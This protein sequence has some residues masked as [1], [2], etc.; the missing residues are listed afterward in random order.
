MMESD[1]KSQ[2]AKTRDYKYHVKDFKKLIEDFGKYFYQKENVTRH[3]KK[4]KGRA[5]S[6][7][8]GNDDEEI[9]ID[10]LEKYAAFLPDL[11]LDNIQIIISIFNEKG[12]N[13]INHNFLAIF[14][15]FHHIKYDHFKSK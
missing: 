15:Y 2:V 12:L 14:R 1:S 11:T 4:P 8:F 9:S 13:I 10:V 6:V 3:T 5:Q 7:G